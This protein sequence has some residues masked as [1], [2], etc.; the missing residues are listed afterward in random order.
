MPQLPITLS[1]NLIE[2]PTCFP[3]STGSTLTRLRLASSRRVRAEKPGENGEHE[4]VD[5]DSLY[6]DVECW[7][8]LAVN[9]AASLAKGLPVVVV[10][11]LVSDKWNDAEGNTRYKHIIKAN[12]VAL[13][14]SR[15]QAS[16]KASTVQQR[17]LDGEKDVELKTRED[18]V[19]QHGEVGTNSAHSPE[20]HNA[21]DS[22][23]GA[24]EREAVPA[25]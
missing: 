21:P 6:I 19:N 25:G 14:L 2:D 17:T 23:A 13:E 8:A 15:H 10:G 7:G 16:W 1:G 9:C 22:F 5:T 4:W 3:F 24:E 11:R 18:M 12:Q 20:P